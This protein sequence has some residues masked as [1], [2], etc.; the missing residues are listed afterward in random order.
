MKLR[1]LGFS[2]LVCVAAMPAQAMSIASVFTR[3]SPLE[4]VV[5]PFTAPF[6]VNSVG[7]YSGFVEVHVSGTGFSLGPAINDAFY[8]VASQGRNFGYYSLG[9][10]T[11]ALPLQPYEP[12]R[13]IANYMH[14]ID[15]VGAVTAGSAPAY[16]ASHDYRFV[17]NLG[18]Q[19]T[20]L[21]FGVM[22]GVFSDNGGAYQISLWQVREGGTAAVPEPASWALL[23]AGFG[24]VGAASRRRRYGVMAA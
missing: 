19:S 14:F 5:A 8:D 23:I 24:L 1:L 18:A 12:T 17:I 22:D 7:L 9:L 6:G 2:A 4:S 21:G 13:S 11:A 16:A 10:G 3:V 15:G 20:L